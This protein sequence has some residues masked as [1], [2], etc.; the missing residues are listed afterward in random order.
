[1]ENVGNV[2]LRYDISQ[3]T[4]YFKGFAYMVFY[5]STFKEKTILLNTDI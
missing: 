5:K 3:E 1:M 4:P 2:I